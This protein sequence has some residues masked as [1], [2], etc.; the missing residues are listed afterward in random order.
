MCA[1]DKIN[2]GKVIGL[3]EIYFQKTTNTEN[4]IRKYFFLSTYIFEIVEVRYYLI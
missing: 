1:V 4:A 2:A 3:F